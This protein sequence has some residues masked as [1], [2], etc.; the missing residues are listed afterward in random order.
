MES[1]AAQHTAHIKWS[2]SKYSLLDVGANAQMYVRDYTEL[3][4]TFHAS[5]VPTVPYISSRAASYSL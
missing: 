2:L 3:N 1:H 4:I 5:Q